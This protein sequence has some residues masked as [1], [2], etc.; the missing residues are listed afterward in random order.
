MET[1]LLLLPWAVSGDLQ[2]AASVQYQGG[3]LVNY[4]ILTG[5]QT[6]DEMGAWAQGTPNALVT[7]KGHQVV[8]EGCLRGA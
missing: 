1:A 2:R 8:L 7:G 3:D 5:A 4:K 6:K